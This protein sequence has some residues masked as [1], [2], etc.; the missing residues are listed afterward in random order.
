MN[1]QEFLKKKEFIQVDAGFEGE[2]IK[3]TAKDKI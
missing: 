3:L 2:I 1:Y